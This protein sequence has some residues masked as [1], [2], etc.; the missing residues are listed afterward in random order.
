MKLNG[1]IIRT[2]SMFR[3]NFLPFADVWENVEAELYQEWV[4]QYAKSNILSPY[5]L[6]FSRAVQEG[7]PLDSGIQWE[8]SEAAKKYQE[9][10]T[11]NHEK[12]N[13]LHAQAVNDEQKNVLCLC[14]LIHLH[15]GHSVLTGESAD[16]ISILLK[17]RAS[18]TQSARGMLCCR[19]LCA[20][21]GCGYRLTDAGQLVS[22]QELKPYPATKRF[23][24]LQGISYSEELGL[25]LLDDNGCLIQRGGKTPL[26]IPSERKYCGV[27]SF[28]SAYMLLDTNGNVHTN[29]QM[30]VSNWTNLRYIYIGLNSA[31]G[32]KN[33]SGGIIS[34]GIN[35]PEKY[36]GASEICTYRDIESHYLILMGNGEA[37]DDEGESY[38]DTTA[39]ALTGDGYYFAQRSGKISRRPFGGAPECLEQT[40]ETIQELFAEDGKVFFCSDGLKEHGSGELNSFGREC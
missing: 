27:S 19:R 10:L 12:I 11:K 40:V 32:I 33:G 13:P 14:V 7:R 39:I 37:F 17:K 31:V 28:L 25:L 22:I 5:V 3:E 4:A 1:N 36:R 8:N 2:E 38:P 26:N 21:D 29:L 15:A 23:K 16:F 20:I 34:A 24:N 9:F 30:D 35:I 6:A 18:S